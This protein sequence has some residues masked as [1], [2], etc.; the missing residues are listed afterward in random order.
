MELDLALFD[1]ATSDSDDEST[2]AGTVD[3]FMLEKAHDACAQAVNNSGIVSPTIEPKVLNWLHQLK[4]VDVFENG[5]ITLAR[6]S[7]KHGTT[8]SGDV[9]ERDTRDDPTTLEVQEDLRNDGW[10]FTEDFRQASVVDKIAFTENP[11]SYFFLAA[12]C[13]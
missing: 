2:A 7:L 8:V 10:T 6:N 13:C 3:I 9:L 12:E 4:I 5:D 1:R 11:A